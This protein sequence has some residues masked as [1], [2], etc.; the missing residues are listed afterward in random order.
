MAKHEPSTRSY[1]SKLVFKLSWKKLFANKS[2]SLHSVYLGC[3]DDTY[4]AFD[5]ENAGVEFLQM[6][7][8]QRTAIKIPSKRNK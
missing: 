2:Y 4:L 5:K 3:V 1:F 7:N 6:L 8:S